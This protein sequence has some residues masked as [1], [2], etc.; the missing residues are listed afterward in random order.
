MLVAI[1]KVVLVVGAWVERTT[2]AVVEILAAE[3][4]LGTVTSERGWLVRG[5]G[6]ASRKAAAAT[7][8]C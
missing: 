4:S 2:S 1:A 8:G 7:T 5:T 6:A 3:I